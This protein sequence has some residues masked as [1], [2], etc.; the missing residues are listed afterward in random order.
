MD[1][2]AKN[3]PAEIHTF[4]LVCAE[5]LRQLDDKKACIEFTRGELPK[6]LLNRALFSDLLQNILDDGSYPDARRPTLFDNEIPLYT[7]P[8][9][10]FTLRLYLWGPGEFT[11]AH[12]HNSWGVLGPVSPGF[13]VINYKRE[14]DGSREGYALLAES[15]RFLL[16]A[17]ETTFTLPF[18]DGIH[19]TGNPSEKTVLSLNFYG[20]T[21]PRGYLNKYDIERNHVYRVYPPKRKKQLL[22]AGALEDLR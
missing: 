4:G 6:L 7:D 22:A 13:E 2:S 9:G 11:S 3:I 12:D 16:D 20:R 10:L 21:L 18:D 19:V 15:E 8:D 1:L 17:G 5:G 14:D